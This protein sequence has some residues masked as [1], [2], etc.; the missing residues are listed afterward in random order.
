MLSRLMM[1]FPSP[2]ETTEIG[3]PNRSEVEKLRSVRAASLDPSQSTTYTMAHTLPV[4]IDPDHDARTKFGPARGARDIGHEPSARLTS[5]PPSLLGAALR[6]HDSGVP[7]QTVMDQLPNRFGCRR[8]HLIQFIGV[9]SLT[10]RCSG[11]GANFDPVIGIMRR[12]RHQTRLPFERRIFVNPQ[13]SRRRRT[14]QDD[15]NGDGSKNTA[16]DQ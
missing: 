16:A 14:R 8:L 15:E 11:T 4:A 13:P 1:E 9:F 2:A 5:R 12:R 10:I 3:D 6:N 7:R